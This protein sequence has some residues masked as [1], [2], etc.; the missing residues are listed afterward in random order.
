MSF[1]PL[2]LCREEPRGS[3]AWNRGHARKMRK[4]DFKKRE[5]WEKTIKKQG[6]RWTSNPRGIWGKGR[7]GER[8]G[9]ADV[10]GKIVPSTSG[11]GEEPLPVP[12]LFSALLQV[13]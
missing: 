8:G 1:L 3:G 11:M 9:D 2:S 4:K 10:P 13:N 12:G 6:S 7:A 5:N